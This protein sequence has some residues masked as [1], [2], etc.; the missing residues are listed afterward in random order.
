[1]GYRYLACLIGPGSETNWSETN[2]AAAEAL[3]RAGLQLRHASESVSIFTAPDTPV[4]RLQQGVV[5]GHIF[6]R[7]GRPA[8]ANDLPHSLDADALAS[9][10]LSQCWG[11][12]LLLCPSS[13]SPHLIVMREPSGGVPCVYTRGNGLGVV[14]SDISLCGAFGVSRLEIDW[15]FIAQ[16]LVSPHIKTL[17]TG[18]KHVNE[19]LPGTSL[20]LTPDAAQVRE[21]WSPWAF[22]KCG[23]RH[24]VLGDA[25][26]DVR[27]AVQTVVSAWA[28][29]DRS[30]LLELSGGLDSSIVAACLRNTGAEL[31]CFNLSTPVPGA[32][33]QQYAELM[34]SQLGV[35]L[36]RGILSFEDAEFA[37]ALPPHTVS[38]G[39][40]ALQHAVDQTMERAAESFGTGSFFSG[41]G[42]DTVFGYLRSAAPAADAYR[43]RGLA[44]GLAS[45]QD[46]SRLHQCTFWKAGRLTLRKLRRPP[47][48]ALMEDRSFISASVAPGRPTPYPWTVPPARAYAG[49]IERISDLAG[50][51]IFRDITLRGTK[52]WMR[53]PLLSQ[54][55]VEACLRTPSW[56]WIAGGRNRAVA[57]A[58][59][60]DQ[61]PASILDRRSKGS[62]A[63]YSGAV[64][65][66]G[67]H[68]MRGFLLYGQLRE[69]G[70][71]DVPALESYFAAELASRDI[72]FMR[73]FA[74]CMVE[75][76]VRNRTSP[77]S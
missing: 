11:D 58:A 59:F 64:Y 36:R 77:I 75:N 45:T 23:H 1:M 35:P 15:D 25:A 70:L 17:R 73:I 63:A 49:D 26:D 34:A 61:L 39:V 28:D 42:G 6:L 74:L 44:A 7:S 69:R 57:R 27:S 52:R 10:L 8:T 56:M 21:V 16:S 22:V 60:A 32:D 38:P 4:L 68:G 33:E 29:A 67:K 62:F 3:G 31:T 51:Q 47:R 46:L 54:P 2:A 66:R 55:V 5:V 9:H 48:S 30:V 41:G 19:L 50:T 53:L 65:R 12:Y 14:T 72:S 71:L 18:L 20:L 13:D 40:A 43:E 37:F 76:W 24:N